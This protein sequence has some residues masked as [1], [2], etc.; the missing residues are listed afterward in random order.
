MEGEKFSPEDDVQERGKK[1]IKSFEGKEISR[2]G[3]ERRWSTI[4]KIYAEFFVKSWGWKISGSKK[5]GENLQS[6]LISKKLERGIGWDI[7][8]RYLKLSQHHCNAPVE[9]SM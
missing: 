3:H 9:T 1:G 2:K 8:V 5:V 6:P 7:N 4:S